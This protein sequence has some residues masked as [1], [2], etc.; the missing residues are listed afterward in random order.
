MPTAHLWLESHRLSVF[1]RLDPT[2]AGNNISVVCVPEG[3]DESEPHPAIRLFLFLFFDFWHGL[4]RKRIST[5]PLTRVASGGV[6]LTG[7]GSW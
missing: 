1:R 3:R 4:L 7:D 2:D 6:R 5:V